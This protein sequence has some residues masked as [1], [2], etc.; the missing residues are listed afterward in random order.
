MPQKSSYIYYDQM[1]YHY[2]YA[3][4]ANVDVKRTLLPSALTVLSLSR[5]LAQQTLLLIPSAQFFAQTH[6]SQ[7]IQ[8]VSDLLLRF[9]VLIGTTSQ[10]R[11]LRVIVHHQLIT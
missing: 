9:F 11:L 5:V 7:I 2:F 1:A 10:L 4:P 3:Q 8:Y 6:R